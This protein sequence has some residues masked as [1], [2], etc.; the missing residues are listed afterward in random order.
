MHAFTCVPK[1]SRLYSAQKCWPLPCAWIFSTPNQ[2]HSYFYVQYINAY[3]GKCLS[4]TLARLRI[5]V[6]RRVHKAIFVV[7]VWYVPE[8]PY[9]LCRGT[10]NYNV[11]C[12]IIWHLRYYIIFGILGLRY[13]FQAIMLVLLG[14]FLTYQNASHVECNFCL[15]HLIT[16]KL[17]CC[18]IESIHSDLFFPSISLPNLR[19][20]VHLA[21]AQGA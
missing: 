7:F 10:T 17:L 8:I 14:T 16:S 15:P 2:K 5:R 6:V 11:G 19:K 13:Q 12:T 4:G 3:L 18:S 20:L 9:Y 21:V 1:N